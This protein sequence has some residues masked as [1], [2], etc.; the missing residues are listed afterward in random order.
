MKTKQAL[1]AGLLFACLY[2]PAHVAADS[3][4]IKT[5]IEHGQTSGTDF[6]T[7]YIGQW[8]DY[9]YL[10]GGY[11]D[12]QVNFIGHRA[13]IWATKSDLS[14]IVEVWVDG[15][16]H[17]E[18]DAH[19]ADYENGVNVYTITDL[20]E[21]PHTVLLKQK[22]SN[23][24]FYY[25]GMS[26]YRNEE[27]RLI[28]ELTGLPESITVDTLSRQVLTFQGQPTNAN[29]SVQFSS[30]NPEIAQVDEKGIVYG[31]KEG[32]TEIV[33]KTQNIERTVPV[34]V[35][36]AENNLSISQG[37]T[38]QHTSQD[39]YDHVL[40]LDQVTTASRPVWLGDEVNGQF[41][42]KSKNQDLKQIHISP[43]DFIS[44]AGSISSDKVQ[45]Y[46]LK[47]TSAYVG[48]GGQKF[49]LPDASAPHEMVPDIL[50]KAAYTDLA[51]NHLQAVWLKIS[52]PRDAK[53]GLYK[54]HFTV[55][56]ENLSKP[57]QVPYQFEV[58][59]I[60]QPKDTNRF[61]MELWQYPFTTARYYGLSE[62]EWF[63]DKHMEI[64]KQQLSEYVKIGGGAITTTISEDPWNHQ[65]YDAYPSMVKWTK[66]ADGHFDFDFTNYDKYVE[67]ALS[68]GINKQIKSF[69]LTPWENQIGYFDVTQQRMQS[70]SLP[71]G[72]AE[73]TA[74]WGEFLKAYIQH[75]DEKGW[76][77]L[78]YMSMDER[79]LETMEHV[80][81]LIEQYKNKNGKSLKI[82]AAM[83]YS[84]EKA[85]ILNHIHD[86]SIDLAQIQ[87]EAAVR[88]LAHDR[89]QKGFTTTLYTCV[90]DYPSSFARS[91][92]V[93]SAWTLWYAQSLGMD[94]Y[95]RWAYDA[96]VK[97]PLT[98]IDHWWWESGDP[99]LVYPGD[100]DGKDKTPRTS[101]RFENFKEAKRQIE[102]LRWIKEAIPETADEID[103]FVQSLV[104]EYGVVNAYGA[105]ESKSIEQNKAVESEVVRMNQKVEELSRRYAKHLAKVY[106]EVPQTAT[107]QEELPAFVVPSYLDNSHQVSLGTDNTVT[108]KGTEPHFISVTTA[109]GQLP[110][111]TFSLIVKS[112]SQGNYHVFDGK[113]GDLYDLY[114]VDTEGHKVPVDNI[115]AKVRIPVSSKVETA[116][117]LSEDG[118]IT[119]L[120]FTQ[121]D[122]HHIEITVNHFSLYG[123]LYKKQETPPHEN[124]GQTSN[125]D[126]LNDQNKKQ[127]QQGISNDEDGQK[128]D[129]SDTA[130][131]PT[132]EEQ[133]PKTGLANNFELSLL[134][135]LGLAFG[136]TF[137]KRTRK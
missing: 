57:I 136:I 6:N 74:I 126:P 24:Y 83:N 108:F 23:N 1:L 3:P 59:P 135:L 27:V 118:Q 100:K 128:N 35:I 63:S 112:L 84:A 60:E 125:T 73:W 15:V 111:N 134:G 19:T 25:N 97:D 103:T 36:P 70:L 116:F 86:I 124:P 131:S 33:L 48:R 106:S 58:L 82:S 137:F 55:T 2:L 110:Q 20:E 31:V 9:G 5:D 67:L 90:G 21:G 91:A 40:E 94:G 8:D 26:T 32:Q 117:S 88:K 46:F 132:K 34:T 78:A 75:L 7:T 66:Q 68:L 79:P 101:P 71:V 62:E 99:F 115:T 45:T 98:N 122:A 41:I 61:S 51:S 114:F 127:D 16:K 92:P 123:V 22:D 107:I 44:D 76:F 69:S 95:L 72:S 52:V 37:S 104:R 96:W 109:F 49:V 80:V 53:P 77:D 56:A 85:E 133:L 47:E 102:K 120:P 10:H 42:L 4:E 119:S 29:E 129:P 54:G 17:G 12:V 65:T 105:H 113:K 30:K 87:D 89:R 39:Q 18:F 14:G 50:D 38:D 81:S 93:E 13:Q 130:S 64:L 43:S 28:T 11:G 121:V